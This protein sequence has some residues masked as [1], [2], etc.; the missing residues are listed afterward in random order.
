MRTEF[1]GTFDGL[2][3]MTSNRQ[4]LTLSVS[5]DARDTFHKLLGKPV[6]ITIE[7]HTEDRSK[8]ANK[9]M[10]WCIGKI[11]KHNHVDKW[12]VYMDYIKRFGKYVYIEIPEPTLER[13][14]RSWR[15]IEVVGESEE[16]EWSLKTGKKVKYKSLQ[17]LCYYGSSTYD[18]KE[19][20]DLLES[21]ISEMIGMDLEPPTSEQMRRSLELWE[22]K[23]QKERGANNE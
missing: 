17:C 3:I 9:L 7:E 2:H 6:G 21:I 10:W 19:F 11:A 12:D 22:K 5:E 1:T 4:E 18:T 20:H 13:V 23:Q 8:D 15:E 16:H 14:K